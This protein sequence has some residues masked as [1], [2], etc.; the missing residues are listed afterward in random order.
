[1][2]NGP[3]I[4]V[5]KIQFECKVILHERQYG[6]IASFLAMTWLRR[7]AQVRKFARPEDRKSVQTIGLSL[8]VFTDFRSSRLFS[9]QRLNGVCHRRFPYFITHCHQRYK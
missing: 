4:E 3:S 1:M 5:V 9:P 2:Q 6:F 7:F 8:S